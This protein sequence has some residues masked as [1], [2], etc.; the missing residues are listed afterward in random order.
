MRVW[1]TLEVAQCKG[2]QVHA[3]HSVEPVRSRAMYNALGVCVRVNSESRQGSRI[4]HRRGGQD[5]PNHP[6]PHNPL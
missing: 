4:T 1:E 6:R 3:C 2:G 5:R